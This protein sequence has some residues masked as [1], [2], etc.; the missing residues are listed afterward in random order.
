[1]DNRSAILSYFQITERK[2]GHIS[3][4]TTFAEPLI[5]ATL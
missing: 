2:K 5:N 1:M 4:N 3:I